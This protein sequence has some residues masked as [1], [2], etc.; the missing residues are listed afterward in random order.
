MP[1][2]RPPAPLDRRDG[3]APCSTAPGRRRAPAPR[4][5]ASR[6]ARARSPAGALGGAALAQLVVAAVLTAAPLAAQATP[7][8]GLTAEEIEARDMGLEMVFAC[9]PRRHNQAGGSESL[10]ERPWGVLPGTAVFFHGVEGSFIVLEEYDESLAG[11]CL[12]LGWFGGPLRPGRYA[13]NRLAQRT[14]DAEHAAD[15]H[16]FFATALVR[17]TDENGVF[18]AVR[19]TLELVTVEARATRGTFEIAG[20]FAAEGAPKESVVWRGSF[21]A[22][23]G[24]P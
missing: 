6:G 8:P 17:R 15:R 14:V 11:H 16:S 20:V 22:V 3:A 9:S 5:R 2:P 12:V 13:V 10:I 4:A 1:Y 23:S 18:L 24:A 21:R 7:A 19:G